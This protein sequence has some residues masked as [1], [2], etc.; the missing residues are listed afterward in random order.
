MVVN[1]GSPSLGKSHTS[2]D[3][4]HRADSDSCKIPARKCRRITKPTRALSIAFLPASVR[5][6]IEEEKGLDD[7][8]LSV[9][10]E[11][12][13]EKPEARSRTFRGL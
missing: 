12:T 8:H 7:Q 13:Q 2:F 3:E 5:S 11:L 9:W 1:H 4:V 6:T 10:P